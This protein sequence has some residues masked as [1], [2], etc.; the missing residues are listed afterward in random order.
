MKNI[1]VYLVI[2]VMM[3]AVTGCT[4]YNKSDVKEDSTDITEVRREGVIEEREVIEERDVIKEREEREDVQ[5]VND[6]RNQT[7]IEQVLIDKGGLKI[8][9]LRIVEDS[10]T[11]MGPE[12]HLHIENNSEKNITVEIKEAS[13]NDLMI[14]PMFFYEVAAGE[15]IDGVIVIPYEDLKNNDIDVIST[16][17]FRFYILDVE[18][19]DI[20]I[21]SDKI[22]LNT[23]A[24][25]HVQT[26]DDSGEVVYSQ[27]RI[28]IVFKGL[29]IS[30]P[31][32]GP[33]I[34]F[35]IENNTNQSIAISTENLLANDIIQD[36][37]FYANIAPG[38]KA[39]ERITFF[40]FKGDGFDDIMK[41]KFTFHIYDSTS[42]ETIDDS[43][44]IN[45]SFQ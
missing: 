30:D 7:I 21:Y 43:D 28:K 27:N 2:L 18:N 45:L 25:D 35:Y 36:G 38:K 8:T 12:I 34:F 41:I 11:I 16:L 13:I 3:M 26:Y 23:L 31:M 10:L 40:D 5:K 6:I 39:N 17:E 22:T 44:L 32:T 1:Y 20:I 42:G 4:S 24:K 37:A 33:Q 29:D 14:W 9:A 19:N 15:Q